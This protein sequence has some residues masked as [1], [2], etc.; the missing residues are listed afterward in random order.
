MMK[1]SPFDKGESEENPIDVEPI[2]VKPPFTMQPTTLV[3]FGVPLIVEPKIEG[4]STLDEGKK[5]AIH[6]D[7]ASPIMP[8]SLT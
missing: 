7:V 5:D 3:L 2:A 4:S 1:F 8:S 6:A